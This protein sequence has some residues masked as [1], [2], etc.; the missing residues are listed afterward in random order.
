M[1]K[2]KKKDCQIPSLF[3]EPFNPSPFSSIRQH[4]LLIYFRNPLY[5][6]KGKKNRGIIYFLVLIINAGV[7]RRRLFSLSS[8][9]YLFLLGIAPWIIHP[10][11]FFTRLIIN[12]F[13][14]AS[15]VSFGM[16][17]AAPCLWFLHFL[18]KTKYQKGIKLMVNQFSFSQ[19]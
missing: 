2:R 10:R 11:T 6:N 19:Q 8:E 3:V 18:R 17:I 13:L 16:N 14:L 15:A 9:G 4:N 7:G 1:S 5:K 12:Y